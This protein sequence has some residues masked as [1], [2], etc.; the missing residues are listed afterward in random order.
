MFFK[1]GRGA[2]WVCLWNRGGGGPKAF[3]NQ[4]CRAFQR[5]LRLLSDILNAGQRSAGRTVARQFPRSRP[6][7]KATDATQKFINLLTTSEVNARNNCRVRRT[8]MWLSKIATSHRSKAST[9]PSAGAAHTADIPM[10]R[11][12]TQYSETSDIHSVTWQL[13]VARSVSGPQHTYL[14]TINRLAQ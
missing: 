14:P 13:H 5:E 8:G 3:G 4:R 6:I 2:L 9:L 1:K 12:C 11:I 7:H 10:F